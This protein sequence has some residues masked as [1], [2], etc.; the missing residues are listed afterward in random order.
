MKPL[1]YKF[2][3][4][5]AVTGLAASSA[6]ADDSSLFHSDTHFSYTYVEA[7]LGH[8]NKEHTNGT[9]VKGA[10]AI[11]PNLSVIGSL[12][13]YQGSNSPSKPKVRRTLTTG[14]SYQRKLKD[15]KTDYNLHAEIEHKYVHR[16]YKG[17]KG[18]KEDLGFLIG[19]GIR[20]E[21]INNLEVFGDLSLRH[22]KITTHASSLP[23]MRINPIVTVGARYAVIENLQVGGE[24]RVVGGGE[25]YKGYTFDEGNTLTA[26]VRYSF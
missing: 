21:I 25:N 13:H 23:E 12:Q 18:S 9:G 26:N 6:V 19:A 14:V 5:A 1:A 20:T 10:F 16:K 4:A 22:E 15:S 24:L 3:L 17:W 7:N 2:V 8:N 11:L